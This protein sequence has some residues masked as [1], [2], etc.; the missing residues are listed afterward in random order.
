MRKLKFEAKESSQMRV[1]YIGTRVSLP[2]NE[3][4]VLDVPVRSG[5]AHLEDSPE[6]R[7]LLQMLNIPFALS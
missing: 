2:L 7:D 3:E 6:N 5:V 1:N 4:D